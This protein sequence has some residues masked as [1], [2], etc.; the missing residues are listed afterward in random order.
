MF[1]VLPL[2]AS[3]G[4]VIAGRHLRR[5][6]RRTWSAPVTACPA[7]R[8]PPRRSRRSAL[9]GSWPP[10]SHTWVTGPGMRGQMLVEL[11]RRTERIA[12]AGDQ[13]HRHRDLR[14]VLH[15]QVL[16]LPRRMQ[17]VA[18][19]D[20][21]GRRQ[22]LRHRHRAH[23]AAVGA[24][25]QH[26]PVRRDA[27]LGDQLGRLLRPGGRSPPAALSGTRLPCRR[28]GKSTRRAR[29]RRTAASTA[30]RVCWSRSAPAPGVSSSAPAFELVP[31]AIDAP[32]LPNPPSFTFAGSLR[33]PP[34]PTGMIFA[35]RRVPTTDTGTAAGI[36]SSRSLVVFITVPPPLYP[37]DREV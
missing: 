37:A 14:K 20:Q 13:Q 7:S 2:I 35:A 33:S 23:P 31:A 27:G 21:P 34:P 12:L 28:Y 4:F 10:V 25:T 22:P 36:W 18:Q 19:Q 24:A 30:T 3:Y 11:G 32:T 16:R 5:L 1:I 26:Q 6:T 17:R 9:R 29:Q 15:P 8:R